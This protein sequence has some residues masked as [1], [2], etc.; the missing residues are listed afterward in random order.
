MRT[1]SPSSFLPRINVRRKQKERNVEEKKKREKN[2]QV[3][4]ACSNC[5]TEPEQLVQRL[6][7][8][9]NEATFSAAA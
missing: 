3:N 6:K 1:N 4:T 2:G 9:G 8:D 7:D 5:T